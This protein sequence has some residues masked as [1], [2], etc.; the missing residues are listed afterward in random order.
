MESGKLKTF[1]L[2]YFLNLCQHHHL[3]TLCTSVQHCSKYCINKNFK[4]S[5]NFYFAAQ[6]LG[7]IFPVLTV[8]RTQSTATSHNILNLS[9]SP[10]Q[11]RLASS[12]AIGH[13]PFS[14]AA[15]RSKIRVGIVHVVVVVPPIFF[16]LIT[17]SFQF[18]QILLRFMR[19]VNNALHSFIT[20]SSFLEALITKHAC[21]KKRREEEVHFFFI[22]LCK[23]ALLHAQ[24]SAQMAKLMIPSLNFPEGFF[25]LH[26]K[27]KNEK[28]LS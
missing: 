6:L 1:L 28:S 12:F 13:A 9:H 5:C 25:C 3:G 8:V 24:F 17:F 27:K 19:T 10:E 2:Q 21:K 23:K 18:L 14:P 15:S 22:S 20:C 4:Q 7:A 16:F 26:V 11:A